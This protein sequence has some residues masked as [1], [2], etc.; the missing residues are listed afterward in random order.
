MKRLLVAI[1]VALV[2]AS[3][4]VVAFGIPKH[5]S[6][7]GT[8]VSLQTPTVSA[9]SNPNIVIIPPPPSVVPPRELP[10]QPTPLPPTVA[11]TPPFPGAMPHPA[12]TMPPGIIAFG[13][14]ESA[15]LPTLTPVTTPV[16]G[17][18]K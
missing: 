18:L 15:P 3:G 8:F 11:P 4:L 1:A 2:L 16:R 10:P 14:L 13:P 6:G 17:A 7:A 12:V 5:S 9:T